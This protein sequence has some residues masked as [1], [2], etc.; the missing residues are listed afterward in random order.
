VVEFDHF[1]KEA[2][3]PTFTLSVSDW[4]EKTGAI[5]LV[6][7]LYLIKE[8]Q[9]LK[10]QESSPLLEESQIKFAYTSEADMLNLA[11]FHYTA[12]QWRD[13]NPVLAAKGL[14]PRD[15]ASIS[16]LVVMVNLESMNATLIKQGL[17][18]R[19]RYEILSEIAQSQLQSLNNADIENRFRAID[20]GDPKLLK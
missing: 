14:N 20:S 13:A 2:G 19:K 18:R 3:L 6:S 16:E 1:R 8:Y 10:E 12:K 7:K 5:G 11:L 4:I 17:G 9:R 15:V